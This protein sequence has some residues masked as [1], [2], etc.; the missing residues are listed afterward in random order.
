MTK[1]K[2]F[3]KKCVTIDYEQYNPS[4]LITIMAVTFAL[5]YYLLKLYYD[6][7]KST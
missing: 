4:Q 7:F 3:K 6:K 5:T 1:E 2:D